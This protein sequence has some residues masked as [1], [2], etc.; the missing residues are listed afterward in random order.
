[1]RENVDVRFVVEGLSTE[2]RVLSAEVREKLSHVTTATVECE[3]TDDFGGTSLIGAN[4]LVEF[5]E[6]DVTVR[7]F[8]LV[9]ERFSFAGIFAGARRRYIFE[10]THEIQS[11][12]LRSDVR[13]FQEKNVQ[14]IVTDVLAAANIASDHF[15]FALARSLPKRTYAVQYR[16]SDFNFISRLLEHEGIF[17]FVDDTED[18]AV[19]HFADQ[20]SAFEALSGDSELVLAEDTHASGVTEFWIEHKSVPGSAVVGDYNFNNPAMDLV[21][22]AQTSASAPGSYFEYA[23]GHKAP[24]EGSDLAKI[25]LEELHSDSVT[26]SGESDVITLQTGRFFQLTSAA[27]ETHNGKYVVRAVIHDVRPRAQNGV[28]PYQ[29][30]FLCFPHA[31]AF[32]PRRAAPRAI[33]RGAHAIVTTGPS[34]AE[35]HT[36]RLGQMKGKFFWDRVGSVDDRATCWMRVVQHPI[37]G[38]MALARVGWEMSVVYFDGDPD[39]PHTFLRKYN[40]E[41]P[42]PY[43]YPAAKTRMSFQTPSS[44]GG[45]KSNEFRM[46]DG[47]GGMETFVNASKNYEQE[48]VNNKSETI[49]VNEEI[50]VGVDSNTI[51]GASETIGIGGNRSATISVNVSEGVGGSRSKTVGGSETVSVSGNETAVVMG[52]DSETTGG[53]RLSAA[54]V[55]VS[56]T[57][58]GSH[59]LTVGAVMV[60]ASGLGCS[61][62]V[63]GVK[64]E[65][66]GGAKLTLSGKTVNETVVGALASTVGGVCVQAAGGNRLGTTKG[67]AAINVGGVACCNAA[68]KVAIKAKKVSINV[69][70]VCNF[71]GGGGVINLTPASATLGGLVVIDASGNV[72]ITGNPNV[73]S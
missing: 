21:Q 57:C 64:A 43:T 68:G 7:R 30:R 19:L 9:L 56:R 22:A 69:L 53:T 25:R 60:D 44:P 8:H 32:R 66:V 50:K 24:S 13:I 63:A 6:D 26:A 65:T 35:I 55:G 39:R 29:N 10:L 61:V 27:D 5:V 40:A 4:A 73:T 33:V 12:A 49:A 15:E 1:M 52:S 31:Q 47:A 42:S 17:Y 46:E 59:S 71:L 2:L 14:E 34:G 58:T 38:S 45:G 11:L 37:G 23:T 18:K 62:A 51:V 41:K 54:A 36:E 20:N 28:K 16:E 72:T 48:T 67:A 3:S 70:G